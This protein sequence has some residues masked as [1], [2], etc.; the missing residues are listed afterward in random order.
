M[1]AKMD[2]TKETKTCGENKVE[3]YPTI[4]IYEQKGEK[5]SKYDASRT[6]LSLLFHLN[7]ISGNFV[8]LI[9]S[10]V[11]F[12]QFVDSSPVVIGYFEK[13]SRG[14]KYFYFFIFYFFYFYFYLFLFFYFIY[15]K[16]FYF[17]FYFFIFTFF[18]F[19]QFFKIFF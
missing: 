6:S 9:S 1:I 18:Y 2:C 13:E 16:F 11:D 12:Q 3:G 8:S 5:I 10:F 7:Q 4:K 15:Y 14:P 19:F 17:Y